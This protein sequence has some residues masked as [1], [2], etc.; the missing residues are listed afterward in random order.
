MAEERIFISSETAAMHPHYI[1]WRNRKSMRDK[2]RYVFEVLFP[3]RDFM[4]NRYIKP[5]HS[6]VIFSSYFFRF[7]QAF[8]GI[9]DIAKTVSHDAH[10][11]AR[12]NRGENDFR[13]RE[14]LKK[15]IDYFDELLKKSKNI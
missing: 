13:L 7:F 15:T 1:Q 11:A 4:A 3:S 6:K 12:L 2:I 10:Y 8:K 9:R 5:K 14:G